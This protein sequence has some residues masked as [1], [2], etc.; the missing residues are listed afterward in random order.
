MITVIGAGLAGVEA[1]WQIARRGIGAQLLEMRPL[2]MTP[3]HRT[4]DFAELVCSNSFGSVLPDRAA[5]QLKWEMEQMGSLILTAAR[6]AA[7]PAGGALA[8]DREKFSATVT[9]RLSAEPLIEIAR[10]EARELP[11]DGVA[12]V[13]SGPLTSASLSASIAAVTGARQLHFYDA[14]A[15]IVSGESVDMGVAWRASRYTDAAG[16]DGDYLN[17]PLTEAEYGAFVDALL[18]A[19]RAE[20]R[21]FEKNDERFFEGCLPIEVLAARGREALAFGPMSPKGLDDP[22]TGRWP[23]AVVQLR[24]DNAAATLYN[25][26]GFQT[27]L[28][29]GEQERVLRMIPGLRAA[30]FARLGQM[31]RNTFINAPLLLTPALELKTRQGLFFGGQLTGVEGYMGNAATGLL[32]G[33]NAARR[34][35]G[36]PLLTLPVTTMLGALCHYITHADSETFQPMKANFGLLPPLPVTIRNKRARYEA[37][38]RRAREDFL[39]ANY[40]NDGLK[41]VVR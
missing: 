25:M 12:V 16:G 20:L 34:L 13:A 21:D 38:A 11:A 35:A 37:Y 18:A 31:H 4:G 15:P 22:R 24:Q 29:W 41:E 7:V 26:V 39:S 36:E 10:E 8:V 5:G 6:A 14:L 1:A 9:A 32:A 19:E 3:A 33:V 30:E 23:Y 40:A 17:C 28:K 2:V 27:N